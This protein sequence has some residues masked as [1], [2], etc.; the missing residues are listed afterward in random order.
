LKKARAARRAG[1]SCAAGS[2][3]ERVDA[4]ARIVSP[5]ARRP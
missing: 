4:G 2:C 3:G 5:P 1:V